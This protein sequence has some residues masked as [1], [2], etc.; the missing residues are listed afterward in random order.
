VD[1]DLGPG[2]PSHSEP[3]P[4]RLARVDN[5]R[6]RLAH[7]PSPWLTLAERPSTNERGFGLFSSRPWVD[8]LGSG[9]SHTVGISSAGVGA[10]P[11]K[12]DKRVQSPES[13]D[14]DR[15]RERASSCPQAALQPMSCTGR[16]VS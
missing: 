2:E 16:T 12:I 4:I 9:D 13:F 1:A 15:R 8:G 3:H 14:I 5:Q 6:R 10:G 11:Y 7:R